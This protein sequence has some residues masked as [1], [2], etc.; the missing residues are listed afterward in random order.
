[1]DT[2]IATVLSI[3]LVSACIFVHYEALNLLARIEHRP[4]KHRWMIIVSMHGLLAAHVAE[5][6]IF[7]V[8]HYAAT[9]WL[10]LGTVQIP[11]DG[12]AETL[13]DHTYYSAMV[14]TTVGF[15]DM[16]PVGAVRMISS[17]EAIA[18]LTL[19]AWSASFAFLRMQ[20]VW[21]R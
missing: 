8:G 9:Q 14:Y 20:R 2:L 3:L 19:I 17:T 15:G 10:G 11:G 13:F 21:R 18:G 16:I 12:L 6:W 5:I 4:G 1:M 7:G